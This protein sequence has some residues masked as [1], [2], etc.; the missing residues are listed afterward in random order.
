MM[1]LARAWHRRWLN[2]V[3]KNELDWISGV[4]RCWRDN[5]SIA[6]MY[7]CT[8]HWC[9][10]RRFESLKIP[11]L[12]IVSLSIS[13]SDQLRWQGLETWILFSSSILMFYQAEYMVLAPASALNRRC[14]PVRPNKV[15]TV[16]LRHVINAWTSRISAYHL[17]STMSYDEFGSFLI[18]V[19]AVHM[20]FQFI[21]LGW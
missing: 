17:C 13:F 18:I 6:T 7:L 2:I 10:N 4:S 12:W 19:R 14:A 20:R 21:L 5:G 15:C 9:S 1:S 8:V 11:S 16:G 3:V